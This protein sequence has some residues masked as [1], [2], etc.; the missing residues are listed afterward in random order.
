[1]RKSIAIL[2]VLFLFGL[3]QPTSVNAQVTKS[4]AT[5]TISGTETSTQ[6]TND[7]QREIKEP[8]TKQPVKEK[9]VKKLTRLPKTG[10]QI[11]NSILGIS[12]VFLT[13]VA[14]RTY[15]RRRVHH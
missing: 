12:I 3:S 5:V 9:T 4:T 14:F 13:I 11:I 2:L 15:Q 8:S 1:M 10:E 6:E 7:T